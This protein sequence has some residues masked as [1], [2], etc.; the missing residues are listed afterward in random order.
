MQDEGDF[1]VDGGKATPASHG[2]GY[3]QHPAD[4]LGLRFQV[5][6]GPGSSCIPYVPASQASVLGE[7]ERLKVPS[8][9]FPGPRIRDELGGIRGLFPNFSFRVEQ[10]M[11]TDK[12]IRIGCRGG[13]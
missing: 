12:G 11:A 13:F 3:T 6:L 8:V 1:V 10:K 5:Y 2:A 9:E 4:T 7:S